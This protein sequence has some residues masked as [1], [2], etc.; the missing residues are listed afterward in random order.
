MTDPATIIP[1]NV[2]TAH[3]TVLRKAMSSLWKRKAVISQT[4]A[5]SVA[6]LALWVQED[7][8]DPLGLPG[9]EGVLDLWDQ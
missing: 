2:S 3:R 9:L 4:V 5:A 6:L 8:P 7:V 1:L